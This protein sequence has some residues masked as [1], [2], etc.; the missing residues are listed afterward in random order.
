MLPRLF[1]VSL[2]SCVALGLALAA[3]PAGAQNT[4]TTTVTTS[5]VA[6]VVVDASGVLTMH[7]V[8][9]HGGVLSR[10]RIA[11]AR[12]ALDA[13]VARSS[14]L[15]KISLN[16]LEEAVR[17]LL[18]RGEDPTEEM[19]HLAGLTRVQYVF[20]Y[21]DTHDIVIAGPAEGWAKDP[22]G[23]VRGIESG[24]PVIE[25]ADLVVALRAFPPQG[26]ETTVISC[27]IDPTK[28]GLANMQQFVRTIPGRIAGRPTPAVVRHIADGLRR[29]LGMQVV[30]ITG[31]P[32]DTHFSQV[33]VEADY[34]MKLIG[35]GL[36][37]TSV[38]LKSY[39]D[40][41][42]PSAVA[43]NALQRWYFVPNYECVR[44]SEDGLAMELVGE[45]VKL[46]G[47][48]EVVGADGTRIKA[49]RVD[50]AGKRFVQGFTAK[51]PE[52]AKAVPVYAQLRNCIDLVVAAAYIQKQD[53]FGQAGWTM[54][55]FGD[56]KAYAVQNVHA[57]KHVESVVATIL[58]GNRLMTPIGGGVNIQARQALYPENVLPD[59]QGA[60]KAARTA[61]TL[62][63]L[64]R[65]Q[66]WWD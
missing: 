19:R 12:A 41:T 47:A 34:R 46:V 23:R 36:E 52:L 37:R 42:T 33:L 7:K 45:G 40:L 30:S 61:I 56:E 21:P 65:D 10:R 58:K 22:A 24:R 62:D 8:T 50:A 64:E 39:V 20:F 13:D 9:D 53:Y 44:Q 54:E 3:Q 5:Q 28:E 55:V 66:W 11:E 59:E 27:S 15:R 32:S 1:R 43:A 49:G 16:R 6:G 60:V 14:A 51:Y 57:P 18:E 26:R 48:D 38:R 17:R 4:T 63:H 31:V 35:I 25:L 29:S 2:M